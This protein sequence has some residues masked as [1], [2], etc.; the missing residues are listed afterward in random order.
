MFNFITN[1]L[2]RRTGRNVYY[3]ALIDYLSDGILEAI[4][5]TKLE[6]IK[7]EYKLTPADLKQAH[8]KAVNLTFANF[9]SDNRISEEEKNALDTLT[10]YFGITNNVQFDEKTF[11]KFYALG[12]I[13]K[14]VLPQMKTEDLD[15]IFK[16]NEILHW[17][18]TGSLK[19]YKNTSKKINYY[20]PAGS[21][22]IL[23]GVQ[24][25]VGSI[26][27][28]VSNTEELVVDDVGTFWIT[29]KR[30]GFKGNR[31]SISFPHTKLHIYEM[32]PEGLFIFKESREKPYIFELQD[33]EVPAMIVSQIL[34]K[35]YQKH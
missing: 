34:N 16:N 8:Q 1:F 11:N 35:T 12:L 19:K 32:R 10:N 5:K 25:R 27:Y 4:E 18:S 26:D 24:Y 21:I 6:G 17:A 20:G 33:Y 14:G 13:D 28:Q 30:I 22:K 23:K 29:N 7:R 3:D 15:I 9:I 2:A 31:K